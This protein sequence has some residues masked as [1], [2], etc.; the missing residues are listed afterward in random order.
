ML[1]LFITGA[2]LFVFLCSSVDVYSF[3]PLGAIY[4]LLWLP[5]L[6]ALVVVPF[7]ALKF[8]FDERFKLFS[9]NLYTVLIATA[10]ILFIVLK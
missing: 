8:W 1:F 7:I 5:I 6:A 4:E 10:A 9:F 3:A 2:A